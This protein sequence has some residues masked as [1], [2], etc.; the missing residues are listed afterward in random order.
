MSTPEERKFSQK[1]V[2]LEACNLPMGFKFYAKHSD[3]KESID[4]GGK[5]LAS[6]TANEDLMMQAKM[7]KYDVIGLTETRRRHPLNAV[8]E[9]GEELFL[10]TCDSRGVGGVCVLVNTSMAENIDSFEQLPTLIGRLR[11]RRCSPTPALTT[12]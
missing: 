5:P 12:L 1:L 4:S 10:G 11:M 3:R 7:I 6:E 2:G 8:Y 9:P